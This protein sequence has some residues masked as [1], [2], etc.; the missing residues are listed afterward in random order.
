MKYLRVEAF[1]FIV[2]ILS[3]CSSN[4]APPQDNVPL[5]SIP[6]LTVTDSLDFF[7]VLIG[8]SMNLAIQIQNVGSDTINVH[9]FFSDGPFI[10][11][12]SAQRQCIIAPGMTETVMIRYTPPDT[13][14]Q[15]AFDTLR[16]SKNYFVVTL[17]GNGKLYLSMFSSFTQVSVS[18]KNLFEHWDN[19][20]SSYQYGQNGTSTIDSGTGPYLSGSW[21]FLF[22]NLP[23]SSSGDTLRARGITLVADPSS[24]ILKL[25]TLSYSHD[26]SIVEAPWSASTYYGLAC[27]NI[28]YTTDSA[29]R[30]VIILS[31][32]TVQAAL[33]QLSYAY[34]ESLTYSGHGYST[35]NTYTYI[36][37]PVD[38]AALTIRFIP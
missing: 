5:A 35:S 26:T 11:V 19:R 23:F 37:S 2:T 20:N 36:D 13:A 14:T 17:R 32:R 28:S 16:S 7:G 15:I 6:N 1:L 4:Q 31:G 24:G 12:D 30:I 29:N 8:T 10:L 21:N 18:F 22:T 25:L 38:S 3:A 33:T 34:G 27:H 9:Q